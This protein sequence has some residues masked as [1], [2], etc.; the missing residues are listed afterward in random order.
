MANRTRRCAGLNRFSPCYAGDEFIMAGA[1]AIQREGEF[2]RTLGVLTLLL[3]L[4]M[5]NA[6]AASAQTDLEGRRKA[7]NDLLAEQ[8]EYTLR[9]SPIYASILGDKR[10]NDKL[11]DFSQ[12]AIEDDLE[13]SRK[14]LARFEG[15]DTTGFAEQEALN[16][17]LMVRDLK[18]S[19]DEPRFKPWEMPV[20]QF[21]G[22]HIDLPQLVSVLSFQN[23]KDYDDYISRLKQ[24][25][26]FFDENVI[27]MRRGMADGLMPPRILLEKV[28]DQA[29][30]LAI[31]APEDTPFAEPFAKFPD[32]MYVAERARLREQGLAVIRDS[33]LPAYVK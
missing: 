32:S 23:L 17:T 4:L 16:K 29:N 5:S 6:F 26:R 2:M 28:V 3:S 30:G 15:I 20:T 33:V 18:N 24:I 14:F 1:F 22:V 19:L 8:W 12:K 31:K 7:L 27:Q 21:G 10:W 9:N 25:P 11:D 13:Q